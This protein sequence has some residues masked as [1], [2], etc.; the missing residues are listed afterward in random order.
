[1]NVRTICLAILA[2][3]DTT[4]YEI[5]KHSLEGDFSYFADA[6]YGSIYPAL[7]RLQAEE[8]VTVREEAQPGKPVRKVYSIT[9]AGRAELIR[10]LNEPI[11]P[12]VFRSPFLLVA[13]FAP[14]LGPQRIRSAIEAHMAQIRADRKQLEAICADGDSHAQGDDPATRW[15]VEY[16]LHCMS[17]KL[18]YLEQNRARLEEI[19]A[20]GGENASR[21][22][23]A[24]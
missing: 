19:A 20:G 12:D 21:S 15:A 8:L 3:G 14:L 2:M 4:G 7:A 1:M 5:R 13:V 17:M 22:A 18:D 16:G 10:A 6:S 11:A 24:E 23:A 9:E